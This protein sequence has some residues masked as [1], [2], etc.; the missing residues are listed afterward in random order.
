MIPRRNLLMGAACVAAAGAAVA[1]RPHRRLSLLGADRVAAITPMKVGQ[2]SGQDVTDLVAP[3]T[4]N[5]LAAR[6]YGET[7]ERVYTHEPTGDSVMV[8]L[9]HGDSQ[10]EELQL[11]R[12]ERCYPSFG[13]TV[14]D[15]RP[16]AVPL[17]GKA[18]IPARILEAQGPDRRE[19]IIYWARIGE[20]LPIDAQQQQLDRVRLAVRGYVADGV[21]ARFSTLTPMPAAQSLLRGF[22]AE[23]IGAMAPAKRRVLVGTERALTLQV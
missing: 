9:A 12:P 19:T 18:T 21:L 1:L 14:S 17:N 15:D 11:H 5:S 10:T 4:P 13:Y 6:L 16:L 23:F 2:W 3:D 20:L 22:I 7:V 8:L